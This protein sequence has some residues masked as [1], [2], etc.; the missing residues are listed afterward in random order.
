MYTNFYT[1]LFNI[2]ILEVNL[3]VTASLYLI[4]K[5]FLALKQLL[6]Y[7]LKKTSCLFVLVHHIVNSYF[8]HQ[9]STWVLD[10]RLDRVLEYKSSLRTALAP[11][12]HEYQDSYD[13]TNE[14]YC[15]STIFTEQWHFYHTK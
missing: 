8:R 5:A 1:Y 11:A 10:K 7:N 12:Q 14:H 3:Q 13:R 15:L 4:L 9:Y 6:Y 2:F